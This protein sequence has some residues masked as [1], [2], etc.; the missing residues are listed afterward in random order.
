MEFDNGPDV[1]PGAAIALDTSHGSVDLGAA[2]YDSDHDGQA[3]SVIVLDDDHEYVVTDADHDG[4]A[5][6]MHAYDVNGHELDP[7]TGAPLAD[8][9]S[10]DSN[11]D[12]GQTITV[13]GDHGSAHSVGAPTVDLDRNGAPDTAVVHHSDGSVT[14]YTDRDGDGRADQITQI[15]ADGK[16]IITVPDGQGGWG[17]AASG[18]LSADGTLV[19]TASALGGATGLASP[20]DIASADGDKGHGVGQPTTNLTGDGTPDTVIAHLSDGTVVGYSDTDG[21][22][23]SGQMTRISPDGRVVIGV[24]DGR[25]GWE[26]VATGW[27]DADG[28]FVP[29]AARTG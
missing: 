3:D 29:E 20:P 6:S 21:N 8:S 14:G 17:V 26:Q 15:D 7:E 5:D 16:V 19:E 22:G 11:S 10:D 2:T 28:T 9:S 12:G 4:H 23:A 27:L 1:Q 13:S 24:P 18:H 25:G